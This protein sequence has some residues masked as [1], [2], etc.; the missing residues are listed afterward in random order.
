MNEFSTINPL[1][2][3]FFFVLNMITLVFFL[4][5]LVILIFFEKHGYFKIYIYI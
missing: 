1:R 3:E 5:K 2:S 4:K